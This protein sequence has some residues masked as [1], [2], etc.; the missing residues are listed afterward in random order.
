MKTE[1]S[2]PSDRICQKD[3][4]TGIESKESAGRRREEE[5]KLSG[6]NSFSSPD[7]PFDAEEAIRF[8]RLTDVSSFSLSLSPQT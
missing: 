7:S 5:W 3:Y 2:F 6:Q 1:A 4:L 8:L